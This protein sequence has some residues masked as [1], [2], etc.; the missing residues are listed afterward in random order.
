MEKPSWTTDPARLDFKVINEPLE[1]VLN[2]II[3]KL[4]RRARD[5]FSEFLFLAEKILSGCFQT[6]KAIRKLVAKAPKYPTQ[7]HILNRTLVDSLFVIEAFVEDPKKYPRAYAL[8]GYR[9]IWEEYTKEFQKYGKVPDWAEYL[10]DKSKLVEYS[11]K[12]YGLSPEER[13]SPKKNIKY[14][15]IPSR[16]LREKIFS[17]E[18]HEFLQNVY[19]WHYGW[20]SALSHFQWGGMS[21]SVFSSLPQHH[22]HPGKFESDAVYKCILYLLMIASEIEASLKLGHNQDLKYIWAIV[23]SFF[24]EAKD[25]YESRFSKLLHNE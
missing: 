18:R 4:E 10:K 12:I 9:M 22:W 8:A 2:S 3:S 17:K 15:P 20:E 7:A 23:G 13:K 24:E 11:A 5:K 14:W 16:M 25:Y 6:Y 19:D 1:K 21:A